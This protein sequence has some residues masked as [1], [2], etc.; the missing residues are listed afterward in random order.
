MGTARIRSQR[1]GEGSGAV[2]GRTRSCTDA[3]DR[4]L[5]KD[6]GEAPYTPFAFDARKSVFNTASPKLSIEIDSPADVVD[7]AEEENSSVKEPNNK[8]DVSAA[9]PR[10][11]EAGGVLHSGGLL[12]AND[13]E[14]YFLELRLKRPPFLA[15]HFPKGDLR[16]L[17]LDVTVMDPKGRQALVAQATTVNA[18]NVV[19]FQETETEGRQG[20]VLSLAHVLDWVENPLRDL[21]GQTLTV[22]VQVVNHQTLTGAVLL[23]EAVCLNATFPIEVP[24][25][26]VRRVPDA[27]LV[28]DPVE[29]CVQ[30]PPIRF[31]VPQAESPRDPS[32]LYSEPPPEEGPN[33]YRAPPFLKDFPPGSPHA[34]GKGL[35]INTKPSPRQVMA[36]GAVPGRL[37]SSRPQSARRSRSHTVE[38]VSPTFVARPQS[39]GPS[40]QSAGPS[41]RSAR[42]SRLSSSMGKPSTNS[43]ERTTHAQKPPA[44]GACVELIAALPLHL[45]EPTDEDLLGLLPQ[46]P[47]K[48]APSAA[49]A[50]PSSSTQLHA[51]LCDRTS[52]RPSPITAAP[53][54]EE[55]SHSVAAAKSELYTSVGDA[56]ELADEVEL[57]EIAV[58]PGDVKVLQ[59]PLTRIPSP[60]RDASAP[61]VPSLPLGIP[62]VAPKIGAPSDTS[63]KEG[64]QP[65]ANEGQPVPRNSAPSSES[66][67]SDISCNS[68]RSQGTRNEIA[69]LR[70]KMREEMASVRRKMSQ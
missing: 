68:D 39:G 50:D 65:R 44:A 20:T 63:E 1:K 12:T 53:L 64:Q 67:R 69:E 57:G 45:E 61:I 40:G 2:T 51:A 34:A 38:G 27:E 54:S 28:G 10:Q 37:S 29:D 9:D 58:S 3:V 13:P 46:S 55:T 23:E 21:Y 59:L 60:T 42:P 32:S 18:D 66:S 24:P 5:F 22:Q 41:Q 31:N 47:L 26:G 7:G 33:K 36:D 14:Y 15:A 19:I 48:M 49:A 25:V 8:D 70:Q 43:K 16:G 30:N 52:L 62:P 4:R 35:T 6:Q 56:A 11:Q 17:S